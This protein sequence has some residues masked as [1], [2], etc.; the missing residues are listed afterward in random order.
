MKDCSHIKLTNC[1]FVMFCLIP[2]EKS[3]F[4][5]LLEYY[6]LKYLE[7]AAMNL[8]MQSFCCEWRIL[9][10]F[11]KSKGKSLIDFAV[12][13]IYMFNK[14][15]LFSGGSFGCFTFCSFFSSIQSFF[16][17]RIECKMWILS[18]TFFF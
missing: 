4:H 1:Q 5:I 15:R 16:S 17:F 3:N 11:F 7:N 10:S 18:T 9:F 12:R 13:A 2:V 8:C 6:V 14:S